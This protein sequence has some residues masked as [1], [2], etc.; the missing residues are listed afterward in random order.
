[1]IF[2]RHIT[3]SGYMMV[4][5]AMLTVIA[6]SFSEEVYSQIARFAARD[7]GVRTGSN[8][9]GEMLSGLTGLEPKVFATGKEQFE[10]VQSVLGGTL[11]GEETELGLGPRFNLDSCGGCHAFPAIGGTS[12]FGNPQVEVAKKAGAINDVPSFVKREGPVREAR[13]KFN[14]DGTPDGGV[15]ALFTITGRSDAAG[16]S[17]AQPDFHTAVAHQNVVFR[18]PTPL[19]GAGLI[20]AIDD[21][22]ILANLQVH[23][24]TKQSLGIRGRPNRTSGRPNTSGNDGTVTRFGWKAQNKSLEIFSGEA[25]NVEQG[26]TNELFPQERDETPGCQIN[27][28]PENRTNLDATDPLEVPSDVVKFAMF[29]RFLAPPVPAPENVSIVRGRQVFSD[30]GCA[31]CHT[32]TLHTGKKIAV[33]A[34]QDKDVNL[35]SDLTLHNM[36]PGLAD[37]VNQGNAAGDEFRTAPLWGLGKR[38]FFLHDGRTK[39]LLEAIQAHASFGSGYYLPSEANQVVAQYNRL[40]EIDK[41][42]VLNFLRSL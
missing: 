17:L 27:A 39:D 20:E 2:H 35:Y 40:S 31:M 16:C 41:Q 8:G 4:S 22:T 29:M 32:P 42:N 30:V 19:F 38:I 15:H 37:D 1:M 11:D 23:S 7:P 28:T 6:G 24:A 14:P 5:V 18:I 34:L 33:E 10:E 9:A 26:V 25:Y 36:G 21:D 3:R 12:P 13:F